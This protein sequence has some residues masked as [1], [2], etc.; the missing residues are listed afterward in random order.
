MVEILKGI[1]TVE[2]SP[3]D[4]LDLEGYILECSEGL[5]MIDT[6]FTPHDIDAYS[7][8]LEAMGR[9]WRDIEAVLIT[10]GHGDHIENLPQIKEKTGAEVMAGL[11]DAEN[12]GLRTGVKIDRALSHGEVIELC[13]GIE[14]VLVPGHS[15]GNLCFYLSGS[16][17][18]IVGDTIFGD[19]EGNL[20]PPPEKYCDDVAKA[21]REISR[22]LDY[23]FDNLLLSHGRN[24]LGD[25]KGA[26][27]ELCESS[28]A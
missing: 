25:A 6:G 9:S 11:G 14:A 10:H 15:A 24:L 19:A 13:G 22:L 26:V 2:Q 21:T 18:M 28:G 23:D 3:A 20:Y 17:T 7:R 8:E 27:D 12:I 1:R 5:V 4:G 16:K